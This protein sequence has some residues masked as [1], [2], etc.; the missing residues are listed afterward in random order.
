MA[1]FFF[2]STKRKTD[3][4]RR[5][6]LVCYKHALIRFINR[7]TWKRIQVWGGSMQRFQ[8]Y[9]T[10]SFSHFVFER[11]KKKKKKS[12]SS[13][14]TEAGRSFWI[15]ILMVLHSPNTHHSC[16]PR[17]TKVSLW[18]CSPVWTILLPF[19][20]LDRDIPNKKRGS[21][22]PRNDQIR[23]RR[24]TGTRDQGSELRVHRVRSRMTG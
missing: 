16:Y 11:E 22:W 10:F 7:F 21:K 2:F 14:P 9:K 19:V 3:N 1:F 24:H 15:G 8:S 23:R 18:L 12:Q 13:N 5:L 4:N 17:D 6:D 20:L